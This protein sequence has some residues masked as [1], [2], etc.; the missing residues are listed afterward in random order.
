LSNA[1]SGTIGALGPALAGLVR[2]WSG[3]YDAVLVLCIASELAA[4]A[5]V[6][7]DGRLSWQPATKPRV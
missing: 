3:N 2:A 6:L 1:V 4:A 7:K 5:I